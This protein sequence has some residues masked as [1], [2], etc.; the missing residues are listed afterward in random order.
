MN[1]KISILFSMEINFAHFASLESFAKLIQQIFWHFDVEPHWRRIEQRIR[2]IIS[3]KFLKSYLKI[4]PPPIYS[5]KF[6]PAKYKR[7]T[8]TVCALELVLNIISRPWGIMLFPCLLVYYFIPDDYTY[9]SFQFT[10]NS[11]MKC[12]K[13]LFHTRLLA[14]LYWNMTDNSI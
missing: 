6:R 5:R 7:Y 11:H 13:Q 10:H 3:T 8:C 1:H 14:L 9:C 12:D 2:E 4:K